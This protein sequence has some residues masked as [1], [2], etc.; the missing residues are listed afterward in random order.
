MKTTVGLSGQGPSRCLQYHAD[1]KDLGPPFCSAP[2]CLVAFRGSLELRGSP[3]SHRNVSDHCV[4]PA[5][6]RQQ[7]LLGVPG[8]SKRCVHPE[9]QVQMTQG[10]RA[11]QPR[12]APASLCLKGSRRCETASDPGP[13]VEAAG[14]GQQMLVILRLMAHSSTMVGTAL[15]GRAC[16]EEFH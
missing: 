4:D 2:L 15:P 11:G 16:G 9:E 8:D 13:A 3:C 12:S 10:L 6:S 7:S 1:S 14:A 5:P